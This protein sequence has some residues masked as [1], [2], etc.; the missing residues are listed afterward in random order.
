MKDFKYF[1]AENVDEASQLKANGACVIAGG[2]DLLGQFKDEILPEPPKELVDIKKLPDA[3]GIC[4]KNGKLSIGALTKL[5]E[6]ADS[7]I[8]RN[9]AP[10]LAEAAHSVATPN[11][12]N[13][14]TLGGNMCQNVRCWFYRYPNEIG[15]RL[16]CMRKGGCECFAVRGDSR[17]HSIF[18][19]LKVEDTPCTHECPNHTDI[20][21]YFELLRNGDIDGA[22]RKFMEVSPMPM[23]T[24]RVCAHVCEGKCNR[25]NTDEAVKIHSIERYIGDYI[26]KHPDK[27]YL[28]PAAETGKKIAVIGAGPAG[29]T[30]AYFLR[31]E[32]HKVVVMDKMEEAGG[33]LMYA[34]PAYRMPKDIIRELIKNLES[35]GIE[36]RMKTE[37]G[38]DVKPEQLE[39]DYD[40]VFYATGAWKRPVLG[41]DGE[42]FTEF[43]LQ[44]LVE[45]NQ[46]L[47]KKQR[48]NVLVVGGGNVAMDVAITAK[49]LGAKTV[50]MACLESEPEMPASKEEIA[51]AREEGI[52]I[53]PSYGVSKAI[54]D[55]D[56][57]KGMELVRCSSVFDA[58]HH[59]APK[60]D[61][62]E[63]L[64]IDADSILMCAGQK[65]D[66]S[67]LDEKYEIVTN[68]GRLKVDPDTQATSRR[69]I[70]AG[71]DMA[72]GPSTVVSA[73]HSGRVAAEAINR[74]YGIGCCGKQ[75]LHFLHVDTQGIL[76]DKAVK[77]KEL[78]VAE[79]ALDKED[80][81]TLPW[82]EI[83]KEA[84]RCLNCGCYSVA[85]SDTAPV[86]IALD[87]VVV[88]NKR[89]LKAEELFCTKLSAAD[90]LAKDEIVL[91]VEIPEH[92]G[93]VMHYDKFR[94]RDSIDFA[95]VSLASVYG[96]EGGVIKNAR[97]VMG[98]VAPIPMRAREA[99]GFLVGKTADEAAARKSAEIATAQ[100]VPF[101]KNKYKVNEI[102]E[103]IKA[104][105]LRLADAKA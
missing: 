55:G 85:P 5:S 101:E 31:R 53:M 63:K 43:G 93:A 86:L 21:G 64:R 20:P 59:F 70:F 3:N 49:R 13:I 51:R 41:F 24:S 54:Y 94:L 105:V 83:D 69:G 16:D 4:E 91:S 11:I 74:S 89:R 76:N 32:G 37:L 7:E 14:A 90:V 97:L 88:T 73:I 62:S 17:Y 15:G 78:S 92:N 1:R 100:A 34:L 27:F 29:L 77:E 98:G 2:T 22:A 68:R 18:G 60:Y 26:R 81:A 71:G 99:E 104:S 6:I 23:V 95:M 66:L 40:K 35:M 28:A 58:E 79:R 56:K 67:F 52:E 102:G 57:V 61:E 96:V 9:K 50:K 12:R 42:E 80:S 38:K 48:E 47:S 87:A 19:G 46:W 36:F 10:M 44:F 75:E 30:A 103:F 45:V 65:V 33:L 84:R 25:G 72:S 82:E 39:K 8:I